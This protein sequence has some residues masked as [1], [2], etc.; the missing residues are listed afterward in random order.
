M[1]NLKSRRNANLP[2]ILLAVLLVGSLGFGG[3]YYQKYVSLKTSSTKTTAQI[4]KE[5]VVKISKV[6]EL[7]TGEEPVVLNVNKDPKDFT[8]DQEK[9]FSQTFKN[10]RKGDVVLLYEKAGLA[11]QYRDLDKKVIATASLAI[12]AGVNVAIIGSSTAQEKFS[13]ALNAKFAGDIK[14]G[15]NSTPAAPYATTTVVDLTGQKADLAKK[16]ATELGATVA[17]ILPSGEKSPA[18]AEIVVVA[19]STE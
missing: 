18:G 4:N 10:L 13:T 2:L 14:L 19:S 6:Y 15:T 7:P 11:V 5:Y 8:T 16:I 9:A 3:V 1:S 12:K 17:T